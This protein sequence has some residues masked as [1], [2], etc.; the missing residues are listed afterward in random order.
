MRQTWLII[1]CGVKRL[2]NPRTGKRF[3][4][5][6]VVADKTRV[7]SCTMKIGWAVS[8]IPSSSNVKIVVRA[9]VADWANCANVR[10][11]VNRGSKSWPR[12]AWWPHHGYALRFIYYPCPNRVEVKIA[13]Q[14]EQGAALVHQH[15][16]VAPLEE[17]TDIFSML[18]QAGIPEREILHAVGR[19]VSHQLGR[20]DE[21]WFNKG[22]GGKNP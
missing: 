4:Q 12:K 5:E 9:L 16:T 18:S 19:R 10:S 2:G 3:W 11:I 14:F 13:H 6:G 21:I 20:K 17:V 15:G 1:C 8:P 22:A 7:S